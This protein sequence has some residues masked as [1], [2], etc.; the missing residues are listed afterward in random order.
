MKK[1]YLLKKW[2]LESMYVN[3]ERCPPSFV[4]YWNLYV[5]QQGASLVAVVAHVL[6]TGMPISMMI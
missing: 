3:L 2:S 5:T 6:S 1:V 4:L